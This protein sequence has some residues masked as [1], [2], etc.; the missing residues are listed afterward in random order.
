[1]NKDLKVKAKQR[2][3]QALTLMRSIEKKLDPFII[4][5]SFLTPPWNGL[6]YKKVRVEKYFFVVLKT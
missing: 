1:M 2:L 3:K 5:G 4:I 6:A